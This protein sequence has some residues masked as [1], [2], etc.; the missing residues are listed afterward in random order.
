MMCLFY[1]LQHRFRSDDLLRQPCGSGFDIYDD[2]MIGVDQIVIEVSELTSSFLH[3][4]CRCGIGRRKISRFIWMNR[5][6]S[7][8]RIQILAYGS[9]SGF[10][11]ADRVHTLNLP[12]TSGI[13]ADQASINGEA[14]ATHQSCPAALPDN[15]LKQ[16]PVNITLA[17]PAVTVLRERG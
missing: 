14:F 5:I 11:S 6:P 4:P 7:I 17:E 15:I 16:H 1:P 13:A 2:G 9:G 10:S 3:I 8:E 12:G